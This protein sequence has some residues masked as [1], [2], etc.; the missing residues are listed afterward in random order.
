LYNG[1][2]MSALN[3]GLEPVVLLA[4]LGVS[5]SAAL[6]FG[7]LPAWQSS[8][9]RP[10]P[11]LR[12]GG[13]FAGTRRFPPLRR[14]L[15]IVQV[16]LSVVLLYGA[17]VFYR[18]LRNLQTVDLGVELERVALL[19]ANLESR[20]YSPLAV[21]GLFDRLLVDVRRIPGVEVA[22]LST[23][24]PLSGGTMMGQET[25]VP[26]FT[27][28]RGE[29]DY[30][31]VVSPGYFAALGMPILRG[32]AFED[33]DRPGSPCVA[34]VNRSFASFY[35]P[36]QDPIGKVIEE[37]GL[38]EVV[39][40]VGNAN[41]RR[42][43]ETPPRTVYLSIAQA[44]PETWGGMGMTLIARARGTP[45]SIVGDLRR[46]ALSLG[47]P[48]GDLRTLETQ[49]DYTISTERTMAF[50]SGIF[51]G[52]AAVIAMAGLAGVMAFSVATRTS[53]IGVRF[54]LGA[55]RTGITLLFFKDALLLAGA[56]VVAGIPLAMVSSRVLDRFVFG[57]PSWDPQTV[58][59]V[60]GL[61]L[62]TGVIA[63]LA[64]LR[65]AV[66]I[67]PAVALRAD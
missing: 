40:L 29:L 31:Q 64:P 22:A 46:A 7:V 48:T 27:G 13:F 12:E 54:V 14:L 51:A 25:K 38:C 8:T 30:V 11:G 16:A 59:F 17:A 65:R 6:L 67:E 4:T 34:I 42:V 49:R 62:T 57:L 58:A 43:R 21:R 3:I 5:I 28:Y 61:V 56:G 15:V 66:T 1:V 24:S 33:R 20:G 50:L 39:G 10:L 36:S 44:P 45:G 32:R 37:H 23:V 55:S 41:Y 63:V 52:L 60:A 18:T 9:S 2:P 26:G 35:W 19:S 47:I 53:E